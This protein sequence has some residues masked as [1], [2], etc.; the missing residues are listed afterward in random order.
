L[1]KTVN[2]KRGYC[3]VRAVRKAKKT[4]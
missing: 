2:K 1:K 3:K 4:V